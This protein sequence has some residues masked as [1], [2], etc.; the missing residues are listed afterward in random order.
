MHSIINYFESMT[1]NQLT[2]IIEVRRIKMRKV[3]Q[4]KIYHR[5][6]N[7][8]EKQVKHQKDLDRLD[9]FIEIVEK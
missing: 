5:Y 3:Q 9:D 4:S 7:D 1:I 6:W 8:N 2:N